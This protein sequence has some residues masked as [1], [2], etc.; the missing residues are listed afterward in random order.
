M[1]LAEAKSLASSPIV[2]RPYA[3]DSDRLALERLA[4]DCEQFSPLIGLENADRPE[5][6]L[7]DI[8]GLEH[9][10][11]SEQQLAN[12]VQK[13]FETRGNVVRLAVADSIGLAWAVT[14]FGHR[15]A[16]RLQSPTFVSA[17]DQQL[18]HDLPVAA[19]RIA[20]ETRQLLGDLGIERVGQLAALP[21]EGLLA[22]FGPQLSLRLDQLEG[23][24]AEVITSCKP[25]L[26]LEVD[27]SLEEPISERFLLARILG[28]L[29]LELT[30]RLRTQDKGAVL[31]LCKFTCVN[32]EIVSLPIYL[33]QP[34]TDADRVMELVELNLEQLSLPDEAIA[35]AMAAP[36][37]SSLVREQQELFSKDRSIDTHQLALLVN[38]LSSRLGSDRIGFPRFRGS[39]LPER[40]RYYVPATSA[41]QNQS[42]FKGKPAQDRLR[43]LLLYKRP[44]AIK[45]LSVAPD[46]RPSVVWLAGCQQQ[47]VNA[48]G[49]ERIET[50]W[51]RG[52]S[53]RRDYYRAQTQAGSSWWIFR[54]LLDDQWFLHGEFA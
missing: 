51:W 50:G 31:L 26:P 17:D 2:V 37:T 10:F 1:P 43:P 34:S 36:V 21:R 27:Q 20:E 12:K 23:K 22:R 5:S 48:W 46:G 16:P 11:G 6:L 39:A 38:R 42:R 54:R 13:F 35:I 24:T 45:A 33:F 40:I 29:L 14:H 49:P 44:V 9:L 30:S 25:Q 15:L 8:T 3:P 32:R 19:L 53:V 7:L 52:E 47:I 41:Q 4:E 18:L 28:K